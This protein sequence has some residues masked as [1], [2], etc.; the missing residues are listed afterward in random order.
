MR[1]ESR[2]GS[3]E[4]PTT[5]HVRVPVSTS[6]MTAGVECVAT[7]SGFPRVGVLRL[8]VARL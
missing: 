8:G 7:V 2:H 6:L 4:Q 1:W 5:A 3:G